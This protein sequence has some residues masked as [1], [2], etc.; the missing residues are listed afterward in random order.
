MATRNVWWTIHRRKTGHIWLGGHVA[1]AFCKTD[2]RR[3]HPRNLWHCVFR[4]GTRQ[5]L[6]RPLPV[7]VQN[8]CTWKHFLKCIATGFLEPRN[9][10]WN[11]HVFKRAPQAVQYAETQLQKVH[12]DY[13]VCTWSTQVLAF[14]ICLTAP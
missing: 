1:I 6:T 5:P 12:T 3:S 2:T 4:A 14:C 11:G 10:L 9:P 13:K 8:S 7:H